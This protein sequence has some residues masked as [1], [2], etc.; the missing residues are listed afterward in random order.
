MNQDWTEIRD[1]EDCDIIYDDCSC[2]R[3]YQ[4]FRVGEICDNGNLCEK[5]KFQYQDECGYWKDYQPEL[6]KIG[7]VIEM[8]SSLCGT[9]EYKEEW[10]EENKYCGSYI[11]ELYNLDKKFKIR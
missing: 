11:N 4:W 5:L 3:T 1:K 2:G 6:Y 9:Y 10:D 8:D 7:D